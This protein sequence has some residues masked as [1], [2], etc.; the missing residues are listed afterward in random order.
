LVYG[1]HLQKQQPASG[2]ATLERIALAPT[3][4]MAVNGLFSSSCVFMANLKFLFPIKHEP[5]ISW[6]HLG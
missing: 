3:Y 5:A 4:A 1:D 6:H 2:A